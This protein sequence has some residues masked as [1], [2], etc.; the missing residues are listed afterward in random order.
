MGILGY[1][2][3]HACTMYCDAECNNLARW[4]AYYYFVLNFLVGC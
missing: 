3:E 2:L 4:H 1:Y